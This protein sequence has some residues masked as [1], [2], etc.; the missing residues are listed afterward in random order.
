MAESGRSTTLVWRKS[1]FSG[2]HEC[3]EVAV[4]RKSIFVRDSK[5]TSDPPLGISLNSWL[6]FLN[7][8]KA[9]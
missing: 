4:N 6:A 7:R 8:V 2:E 9:G 3:V 1:T 5:N